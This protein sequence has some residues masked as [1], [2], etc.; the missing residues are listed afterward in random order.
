MSLLLSDKLN[1]ALTEDGFTR[2]DLLEREEI[3][4][5]SNLYYENT[6]EKHTGFHP[7]MLHSS[8]L[9]KETLNKAILDVLNKSWDKHFSDR[10]EILYGNFMVKEP[11]SSS[12]MK[13]HQDWTYVDESKYESFAI[14]IPLLDLNENNGAFSVIPKSHRLSNSLRGPGTTCPMQDHEME[15]INQ[16]GKPVYLKAGEA[17][18][19]NH[20][21]GH[22]SPPN[23]SK[24]PRIAITAIVVPKGIPIVH[25][26]KES[27]SKELKEY[28]VKSSFFMN[29]NIV[30]APSLPQKRVLKESPLTLSLTDFDKMLQ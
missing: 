12:K 17:V 13:L 14:W 4:G 5:L 22:Y 25:Y 11:D 10:Y 27:S 20:R 29:Y 9:Y 2:L 24:F 26:F 18:I 23:K 8:R 21:L 30:D 19:W 16:Y 3:K 7:S 6:K 28:E 1:R 15:L